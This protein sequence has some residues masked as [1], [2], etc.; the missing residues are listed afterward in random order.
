MGLQWLAPKMNLK[1]RS[2][3]K[4]SRV[5]KCMREHGLAG[6][7]VTLNIVLGSIPKIPNTAVFSLNLFKGIC[8]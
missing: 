4:Q 2:H 6:S 8:F 5:T 3:A 1:G 7:A